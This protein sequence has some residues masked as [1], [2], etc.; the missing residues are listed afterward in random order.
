VGPGGRSPVGGRLS[1]ARHRCGHE[2]PDRVVGVRGQ[3]VHVEPG[4][5]ERL[6]A[7]DGYRVGGC[8]AQVL[9]VEVGGRAD[10]A[11][12]HLV[13]R[14]QQRHRVDDEAVDAALLRGLTQ[15]GAGERGVVLAVAPGLQPA[16]DPG[17]QGEQHPSAVG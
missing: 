15:G 2:R 14:E 8:L 12:G 1:Q 4:N 10:R 13:V 5:V 7:A 16:A 11:A 3:R 6:L 9:D 17:M